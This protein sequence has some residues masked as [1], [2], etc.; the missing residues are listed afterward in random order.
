[1]RDFEADISEVFAEGEARRE[2]LVAL[3]PESDDLVGL[4]LRGHLVL[5]ELLFVACAAFCAAPEHLK[6]ARLRFPQLVSLLRSLEKIP[7]VPDNYWAAL[8]EL[9]SLR[10]LLAHQLE[11]NDLESR[12]VHFLATVDLPPD[13]KKS[14]QPEPLRKKLQAALHFLIGGFEVA[15]VWHEGVETLLRHRALESNG[16]SAA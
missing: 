7:S 6:G 11:H 12:I 16:E 4:V 5:E 13:V 14:L 10:N 1:M 15:A 3:L 8:T 2:R 9:N